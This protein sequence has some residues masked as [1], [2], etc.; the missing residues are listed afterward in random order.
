MP[1]FSISPCVTSA[2]FD[3][4]NLPSTAVILC[5]D[6]KLL[7]NIPSR[8]LTLVERQG[9]AVAIAWSTGKLLYSAK[10]LKH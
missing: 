4:Q 5:Q 7:L 8:N 10:E 3:Y 9:V 1:K 6:K 2:I